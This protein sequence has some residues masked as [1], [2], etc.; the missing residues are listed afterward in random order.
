MARD[1]VDLGNNELYSK[2]II[3][4]VCYLFLAQLQ[5]LKHQNQI[6]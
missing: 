1:A 2:T 4:L 3:Q 5:L 6:V